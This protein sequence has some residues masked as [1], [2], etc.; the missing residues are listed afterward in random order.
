MLLRDFIHD[1]RVSLQELYPQDEARAIVSTFVCDILGVSAQKH[2]LEP[3]WEIPLESETV[4]FAAL[5]RLQGGEPMQ[6]VLGHTEFY[7]RRFNVSPSVL[8]PRP[9]T[10]LMVH[11][12]LRN[13]LTVGKPDSHRV[14][15]LCTGSGCIAWTMA[16]ELP[17][18]EVVAL[19]ISEDALAVAAGQPLLEGAPE[20]AKAPRFL[21]RDVLEASQLTD[22]GSFDIVLSNPPYVRE[23]E[24]ALM[25]ENVLAHEPHLALFVS[26]GDPLL[27]YRAEAAAMTRFLRPG[28]FGIVEIN[29]SLGSSTADLFR[30]AGLSEVEVLNDFSEK[31]R[32]VFFKRPLQ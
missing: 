8:I 17:G 7:G 5:G 10:E 4:L 20:G 11:L 9:E 29:E 22:L 31:N 25:R 18:S 13:I 3:R 2:V 28:G 30:E 24:K 6:Y 19:D 1:A 21:R 26:D 15:D 12:A 27:F 32:F 16:L 23:S 14:L